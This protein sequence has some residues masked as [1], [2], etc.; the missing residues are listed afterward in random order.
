NKV[1]IKE[2]ED[3]LK[4]YE[5]NI[6]NPYEKHTIS[7]GGILFADF[8]KKY[9]K[10]S[11]KEVNITAIDGY[12]ITIYKEDWGSMKI[13]LA[14][15]LDDDYIPISKKG[16]LMVVFPEY[17]AKEKIYQENISKWIWMIRKIEFK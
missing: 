2:L 15:R 11:V 13:I 12:Y 1:T 3:G 9:S 17:D 6:Y 10:D 4:L 16:P 8:L 7:Y 14:T 5:Y